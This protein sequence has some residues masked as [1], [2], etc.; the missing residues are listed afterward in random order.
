MSK[1]SRQERLVRAQVR[2]YGITIKDGIAS[3]RGPV[4]GPLAGAQPRVESAGELDKRVTG[5]RFCS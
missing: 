4:E 2:L 3:K 1:D 5:T